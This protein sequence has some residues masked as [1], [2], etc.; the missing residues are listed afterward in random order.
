MVK[1]NNNNESQTVSINHSFLQHS[2]RKLWGLAL[3]LPELL[4][5]PLGLGTKPPKSRQ[6]KTTDLKK[7]GSIEPPILI[8]YVPLIGY[9]DT[10]LIDPLIGF[11]GV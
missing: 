3:V 11:M 5:A 10:Y 8:G 6:D 7:K 2:N 1:I 9:L 4:L